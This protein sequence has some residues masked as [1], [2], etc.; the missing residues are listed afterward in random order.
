M[1]F[2]FVFLSLFSIGL[3]NAVYVDDDISTN[4]TSLLENFLTKS[5]S[6]AP[7][8]NALSYGIDTTDTL[9]ISTIKCLKSMGYER[10]FT[11]RYKAD[12][13]GQCDYVGIRNSKNVLDSNFFG[14][15]ENIIF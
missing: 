8:P 4:D 2:I 14:F 12:S 6:F 11:R 15:I 1:H 3:S 7:K 13:N 10:F 9:S 5:G